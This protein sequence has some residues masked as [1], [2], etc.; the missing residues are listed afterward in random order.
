MTEEQQDREEGFETRMQRL[1]EIVQ[2]LEEGDLTLERSLELF[3][4]GV[5]LA[6]RLE[7]Q[8]GKA[9]MKV[10]QLL[11]KSDGS[12]QTAP[13]EPEDREGGSKAPF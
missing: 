1:E 9:E 6:R 12:E 3:E 10:E 8:L 13:F 4:E 7:D 2:Q 5:A 11:Q